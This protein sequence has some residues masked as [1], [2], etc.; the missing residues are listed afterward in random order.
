MNMVEGR[1]SKQKAVE[2]YSQCQQI[3]K[4]ARK[5]GWHLAEEK[6]ERVSKSKNEKKKAVEGERKKKRG[7]PWV[8]DCL[9]KGREKRLRGKIKV[10]REAGTLRA[11]RKSSFPRGH[12]ERCVGVRTKE[13][14]ARRRTCGE[15]PTQKSGKI[16]E[17]RLGWCFLRNDASRGSMVGRRG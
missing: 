12:Q 11:D 10:E 16:N 8:K 15:F 1:G 6:L 5:E 3:L 17:Q 9:R 13:D 4:S 7:S 2:T 14:G